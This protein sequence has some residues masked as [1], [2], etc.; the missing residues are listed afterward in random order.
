[1][2]PRAPP[3]GGVATTAPC[4]L[5]TSERTL[6]IQSRSA[7]CRSAGSSWTAKERASETTLG[8]TTSRVTTIVATSVT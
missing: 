1:M 8:V 4:T 6:G 7:R 3:C 2:A 5:A